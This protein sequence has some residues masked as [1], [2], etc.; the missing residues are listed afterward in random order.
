MIGYI[1]FTMMLRTSAK[2]LWGFHWSETTHVVG[3]IDIRGC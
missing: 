1:V 2:V 3:K